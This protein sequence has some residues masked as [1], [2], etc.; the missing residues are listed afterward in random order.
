MKSL[1]QTK[2]T[3]LEAQ[4]A[5]ETMLAGVKCTPMERE[6]F[7]RGY[8]LGNDGKS[9]VDVV[10]PVAKTDNATIDLFG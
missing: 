3:Y 4:K 9:L 10:D 8:L 6:F 7:I 2:K 1:S 5:L